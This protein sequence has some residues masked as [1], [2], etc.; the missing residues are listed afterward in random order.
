MKIKNSVSLP[1][2]RKRK[3]AFPSE[4]QTVVNPKLELIQ[5]LI[6]IA[7][8]CVQEVLQQEV[9]QLAGPRYSHDD[10]K[11]EYKRWG[12][13]RGSIYLGDQKVPIQVPRVRNVQRR[14]EI[15]LVNY[16]HLQR[17]VA[18]E[19]QLFV[20]IIRGLSCRQYERASRLVPAA[21]GLSRN[22]ISR[23]FI[24]QSA[25][26]LKA[27]LERRLEPYTFVALVLDG[28]TFGEA[29]MIIALGITSTGEKVMLGFVESGTENS[30]VC[31]EFLQS[32][33]ARGLS[34]Q[35]G[36]LAVIDGS[37]G[38]RKAI[39]EVFGDRVVVQRCQWHKREN[40]IAYLPKTQQESMRQKLQQ[41]YEQP[42]YEQAHGALLKIR[43]ELQSLN[44]SAVASLDEGLEETLTLHR[45]GLFKEL[46][47]SLKT[48]NSLESINAQLERL[49]RKVT[50]W[51][52]SSQRQRWLASALLEIEPNLRRIKGYRHLPQLQ[53]ALQRNLKRAFQP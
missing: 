15:P 21:F 6:P 25:K 32:L 39:T 40:V 48:T 34:A 23:R 10:A 7:L 44:Q 24:R 17:P 35:H 26:K 47:V 33:V 36:L 51:R 43:R 11:G 19:D 31:T 18:L 37:K 5:T 52:N 30:R 45:L 22:Q 29:Q 3:T 28:K 12:Q 49:T 16:H 50:H 38:L 4:S 1:A 2:R 27:L 8:E 14:Q 46:G 41:A 9:E 13:Q 42:T 20:R 53:M